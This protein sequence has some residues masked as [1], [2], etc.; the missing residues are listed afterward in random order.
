MLCR[1]GC[2]EILRWKSDGWECRIVCP[3]A[4]ILFL[5]KCAANWWLWCLFRSYNSSSRSRSRSPRPK[6]Q[7]PPPQQHGHAS[8][9]DDYYSRQKGGKHVEKY[10]GSDGM[11][12]KKHKSLNN[13]RPELI[14]DLTAKYSKGNKKDRHYKLDLKPDDRYNKKRSKYA[15]DEISPLPVR[16]YSSS[17]E[18]LTKKKNKHKNK[19][20]SK[21]PADR[22][23]SKERNGQS[24]IS[25]SNHHARRV[26]RRWWL[27]CLTCLTLSPLPINLK[28]SFV[29]C[30]FYIVLCCK[31]NYDFLLYVGMNAAVISCNSRLYFVL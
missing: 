22:M 10:S 20:V 21:S 25:R 31:L 29:E 24:R 2:M 11:E 4:D 28:F 14:V 27:C 30:R 26:H 16:G 9:K 5:L 3:V 23:E 6:T 12:W 17:P 18:R 13:I 19:I 15:R 1:I 8:K 7:P